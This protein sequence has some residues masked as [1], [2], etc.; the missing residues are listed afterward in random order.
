MGESWN[1]AFKFVKD[2]GSQ[3]PKAIERQSGKLLSRL[4][5][6]R[7]ESGLGEQEARYILDAL[8][9]LVFSPDQ[10]VE[11]IRT[12]LHELRHTKPQQLVP[13]PVRSDVSLFIAQT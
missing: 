4:V 9:A 1:A 6:L 13:S 11:H 7:V 10:L 3:L 2:I 12:E 5:P 8:Q